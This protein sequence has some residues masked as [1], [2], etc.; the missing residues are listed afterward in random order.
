MHEL[1]LHHTIAQI[2]GVSTIKYQRILGEDDFTDTRTNTNF[3]TL[4]HLCPDVSGTEHDMIANWIKL[5]KIC[6][7]LAY[8]MGGFRLNIIRIHVVFCAGGFNIW[9]LF[10]QRYSP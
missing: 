3:Q 1:L 7:A 2:R 10:R 5:N 8:N 9:E 6:S 4:P